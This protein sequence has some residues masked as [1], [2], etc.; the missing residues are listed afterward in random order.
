MTLPDAQKRFLRDQF[1]GLVLQA[2]VQRA[3]IYEESSA[4]TLR[5]EFR[6]G[7][8]RSLDAMAREYL[9]PVDDAAHVGRIDALA[10][11]MTKSFGRTLRGGRFRVGP[12]QKALNLFLKYQW[13]AGWIP[14]PP[15]CPFDALII[16]RLPAPIRT[17]WTALDDLDH[18]QRLVDAARHAAGDITIAEWE[19]RLYDR[20]SIGGRRQ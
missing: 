16:G 18:Y 11:E 12:A 15:H 13:C 5:E 17:A 4:D 2:T 6:K 9:Q 7:L 3:G 8:R 19:L 20:I 14:S 10:Q 1:H